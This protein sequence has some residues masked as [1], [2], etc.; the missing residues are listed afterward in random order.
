MLEPHYRVLTVPEWNL[1][2]F[3]TLLMVAKHA[4]VS[5]GMVQMSDFFLIEKSDKLSA[6]VHIYENVLDSEMLIPFIRENHIREAI[7]VRN[8]DY[9]HKTQDPGTQHQGI[10]VTHDRL[11]EELTTLLYPIKNRKLLEEPVESPISVTSGLMFQI[12]ERAQFRELIE[13]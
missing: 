13:S 1:P 5:Q 2:R 7:M 12:L 10:L 11:G 4:D 3:L 8:V 9:H 6:V